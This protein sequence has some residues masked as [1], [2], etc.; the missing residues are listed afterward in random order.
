MTSVLL[1]SED[2]DQAPR[3]WGYASDDYQRLHPWC[4]LKVYLYLGPTVSNNATVGNTELGK[5]IRKAATNLAKL[6]SPVWENNKLSTKTKVAIYLTCVGST[7]LWQWVPGHLC[8]PGEAPKRLQ[9]VGVCEVGTVSKISDCQPEGTG[10][11]P[12]PGRGLNFG[13]PSFATPSV[14]RDVKPFV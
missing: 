4:H 6:R 5:R 1:K 12:Q 10:L 3:F 9:H 11:N 8:R 13:R 14:D 2:K 7:L